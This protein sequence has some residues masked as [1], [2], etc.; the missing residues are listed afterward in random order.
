MTQFRFLHSPNIVHLL[1]ITACLLLAGCTNF[2]NLRRDLKTTEKGHT[3]IVRLTNMPQNKTSVF[4][5][6]LR[7]D[8]PLN[9]V[10]TVDYV[11]VGASGV[12]AFVVKESDNQFVLAF[13]DQNQNYRYDDGEPSWIHSHRGKPSSIAFS[14]TDRTARLKGQ[15]LKSNR[16][17]TEVIKGV[18]EFVGKRSFSALSTGQ[19]TT[20]Q[21]GDVVNPSEPRFAA[22]TGEEGL[23]S[24]ASFAFKQKLGIYFL[25]EYAPSKTPVIFVHGAAGSPQDWNEFFRHFDR[26]H[27]QLWFYVYPSGA[28]LEIPARALNDGINSLHKLY[29]FRQ[30]HVVAHSMGGLVSRRAVTDN[31]LSHG[32]KY[33][34]KLVTISTPFGG[35]EAAEMG[36]KMSPSTV[37]SWID[38]APNSPFQRE[39]FKKS[40]KDKLQHHIII[41]YHGKNSYVIPKSNDGTVSIASQLK[42]EAQKEATSVHGFDEDH[43]SI[44]SNKDVIKLVERLLK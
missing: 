24:P 16:L 30:I 14:P 38:M 25:E 31:V 8:Q 37:P 21:L 9:K 42:S 5:V 4:A 15:L 32:N 13:A 12:F 36:V 34:I 18:K 35:H 26:K 6:T 10:T 1:A 3:V 7:W 2:A 41:S 28:R 23:W 43:M 29:G 33:H 22:T 39:L 20:M 40:I 17:P 44:L 11:T 19:G 27:Y